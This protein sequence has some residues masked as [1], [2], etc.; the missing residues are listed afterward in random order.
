MCLSTRAEHRSSNNSLNLSDHFGQ[1][2]LAAMGERERDHAQQI[3]YLDTPKAELLYPG[4]TGHDIHEHIPVVNSGFPRDQPV[5]LARGAGLQVNTPRT[6]MLQQ[7]PDRKSTRLQSR[8]G[9]S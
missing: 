9:I 3:D 1:V 8:F 5:V 6:T 2:L 7:F 4:P